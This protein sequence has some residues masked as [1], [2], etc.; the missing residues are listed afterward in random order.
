M[1]SYDSYWR[2]YMNVKVICAYSLFFTSTI[3]TVLGLKYIPLS[4]VPIIESSGYIFI[5]F[6]SY[7]FLQEKI[8]KE[9]KWGMALIILGILVYS[10]DISV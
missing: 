10:I 3:I 7:I 9:Q 5:A 6:L 1:M 2:E 4:F 8:R